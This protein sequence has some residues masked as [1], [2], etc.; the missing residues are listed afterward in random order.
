MNQASTKLNYYRGYP[1]KYRKYF[2]RSL[3]WAIGFSL[4]FLFLSGIGAVFSLLLLLEDW[5]ITAGMGFVVSTG[6][7]I[8]FLKIFFLNVIDSFKA[9]VVPYFKARVG[10]EDAFSSG[11]AIA[12]NCQRLDRI[13]AERNLVPIS[14]FGFND[15][16]ED[17]EV[18]W[19]EPNKGLKSV[20]G[21]LDA[22][23]QNP[24]LLDKLPVVIADLER[25]KTALE[26]AN[27]RGIPF[28]FILRK[29]TDGDVVPLEM[30]CRKGSF[31]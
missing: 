1:G 24:E 20:Q 12:K 17:E 26:K 9:R 10:R 4:P 15:D 23:R 3:S 30:D 25:I 29:G 7:F 8:F 27:S 6:F 18:Q 5:R 31:W 14:V 13:A 21:L 19:H 16:W 2:K 11:A 22:L 28:C